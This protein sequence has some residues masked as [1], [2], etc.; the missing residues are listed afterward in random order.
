[1]TLG[2]TTRAMARASCEIEVDGRTV[3]L[4]NPDKVFFAARGETKLDL[5]RY[6]LAMGHAA[7]A[8]VH[9]RP[10]VLKR[11][12]DGA[13]GPFFFQKRV[14]ERHPEWLETVVVAFPSGR[15]AEELC[16]TAMAHLLWAI[17]LGCIDLNP[18]PV[19]RRDL[20]HPDELRVDLDPE[21]GVAFADVR[22]TA[23]AAREVLGERGLLSYPKTSGA[24]GMHVTVPLRPAW[25]FDEVRTAALA[26]AR[27]L[28]RRLPGVATAAWWK[29]D[30]HERV[31]VDYNQ[32]AR[33]RTVASAYSVRP[34]ADARVSA[35][36]TWEEVP[37][38]EPLEL[39]LASMPTRLRRVGDLHPGPDAPPGD[40][41]PLLALAAE[42]ARA[43]MDDAP[44]PP[45][46]ARRRTTTPARSR[47]A[48]TDGEV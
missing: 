33:D 13:A 39:T 18:W 29:K 4:T 10:T 20:E 41:G 15:R 34:T 36:L 48:P 19:R 31:L 21:P 26:L 46:F 27:E 14:P 5:A 6:Y 9:E 12:P 43:G 7:L 47:T 2:G 37:D 8:A 25:G 32:N 30:R 23:L 3:T 1:M 28:E 45:F 24:T 11:Y 17:N 16:P 40:L 42:Q 35:P 38:V 44:W 22:R